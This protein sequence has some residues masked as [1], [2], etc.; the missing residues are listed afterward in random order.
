MY[1]AIRIEVRCQRY[2]PCACGSKGQRAVAC[3]INLSCLEHLSQCTVMMNITLLLDPHSK[4]S[5]KHPTFTLQQCIFDK[6][7]VRHDYMSSI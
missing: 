4:Q 5:T 1:A 2:I 7:T 3:V 6:L